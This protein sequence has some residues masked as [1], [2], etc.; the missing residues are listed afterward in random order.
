M[1]MGSIAFLTASTYI[2][3]DLC[4]VEMDRHSEVHSDRPISTGEVSEGFAKGFV[5]VAAVLGLALSSMI[6]STTL[7]LSAAYWVMFTLY[8][9]PGVRF[10]KMFLVKELVIAIAWPMLALVGVYA[11]TDTFSMPG[12]FAGLMMGMF[13]FLGMPALSDSFDEKED[14]MYGV[15]TMARA[16]S[17]K[18]RVEFLGAALV[19]MIVVTTLTYTRLGFNTLLPITIVGSSLLILR[20]VVPIY[21]EYNME[22]ALKVR[23]FTYIYVILSQVFIVIGSLNLAL[24]F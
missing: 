17:W 14:A 13:S 3:N 12:I 21:Q 2:Y 11:V 18:R 7:I 1:A 4:D 8:S 22:Q 20:S 24:P 19:L 6:N 10:K 16:L 9:Y 5:V 15:R 23:K